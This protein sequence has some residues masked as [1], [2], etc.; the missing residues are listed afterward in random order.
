VSRERNRT[1]GADDNRSRCGSR[2]ANIL[3]ATGRESFICDAVRLRLVGEK[4]REREREREKE[5]D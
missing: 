5:E 4:E 2:E 1:T 3:P